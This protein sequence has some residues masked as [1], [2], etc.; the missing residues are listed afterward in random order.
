MLEIFAKLANFLWLISDAHW[1][2]GELQ[3]DDSLITYRLG[4]KQGKAVANATQGT[5][6]GDVNP[7]PRLCVGSSTVS[8]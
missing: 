3:Q 6:S 7:L 1:A 8:S 4:V 5:G 2:Y